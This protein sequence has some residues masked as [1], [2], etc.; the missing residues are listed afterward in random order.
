MLLIMT[1]QEIFEKLKEALNYDYL[2]TDW[3]ETEVNDLETYL[4]AIK[5]EREIERN[6]DDSECNSLKT[7]QEFIH[8][9]YNHAIGDIKP[10]IECFEGNEVNSF[11][12]YKKVTKELKDGKLYLIFEDKD[13]DKLK[14]EWQASDNY[15]VW[16]RC[17]ICGDDYTGFLLFPTYEDDE[18]FC[19]WYKC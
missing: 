19:L 10:L 14:A 9:L 12:G 4:R 17:G 16:Q 6:F 5:Q 8:Y 15:A 13:G 2:C 11:E 3:G 1:E 18:Y 7:Y